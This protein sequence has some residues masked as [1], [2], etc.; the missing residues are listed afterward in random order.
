MVENL[1]IF[2]PRSKEEEDF[3]SKYVPIVNETEYGDIIVPERNIDI[4]SNFK[5]NSNTTKKAA[6]TLENRND[7]IHNYDM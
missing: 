3:M 5:S 1:K 6:I 4:L 7:Y 2:F